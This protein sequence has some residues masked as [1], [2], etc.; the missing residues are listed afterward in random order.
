MKYTIIIT[1]SLFPLLLLGQ[2]HTPKN[3]INYGIGYYGDVLQFL[4]PG[5][6]DNP[7]HINDNP[8]VYGKLLHGIALKC[9]YER[10][11]KTG[12]IFSSNFHMAKINS[13]YNDPLKLYWDSQQVDYYLVTEF[14]FSK[15]LVKNDSYSL[16]P[17]FGILYRQFISDDVQY[18]F[19]MQDNALALLSYPEVDKLIMHDLGLSF[20]VD[21]RYSFKNNLFAGIS[22]RTNL[23]FA[24]GIETIN[25]SPVFGVSF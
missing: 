21:F 22:L 12:F 23:I 19:G 3:N 17:N 7:D 1:L 9:G 2:E 15:D 4:S 14:S 18:A 5:F 24:I 6:G 16:I 8:K 11:L 25:I 10:L 20:G 13:Y